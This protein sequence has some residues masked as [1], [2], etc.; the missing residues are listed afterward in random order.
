MAPK[1][2]QKDQGCAK[3]GQG[4]YAGLRYAPWLGVV[5]HFAAPTPGRVYAGAFCGHRKMVGYQ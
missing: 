3:A 1:A 5:F 2:A 4:G